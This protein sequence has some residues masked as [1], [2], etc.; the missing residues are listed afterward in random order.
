MMDCSANCGQQIKA[1][2]CKFFGLKKFLCC[3]APCYE[4]CGYSLLGGV[5]NGDKF[6]QVWH[7]ALE[8]YKK[9]T[10]LPAKEMAI[11]QT[12]DD[13]EIDWR[14]AKNVPQQQTMG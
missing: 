11:F 3:G 8:G 13:C 12:I 10:E 9:K 1:A 2:P 7:A 14:K 6:L 5:K 4:S